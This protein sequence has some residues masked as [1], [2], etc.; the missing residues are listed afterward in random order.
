MAY[1]LAFA[2]WIA[3]A[4][5]PGGAWA[6]AA[7]IALAVSAAGVVRQTRAGLPL[8]AQVIAIGS[9]V[10]FAALAVL[11][12]A[13]PHT[14]LHAYTPALASGALALIGIGS[15]ALREPFTL[16]IAK[17]EMPREAWDHPEFL[18]VNVVITAVW[19]AS[20]AAGAV[21]L[22][23]LAHSPAAP[24]VTVQVAAFVVPMV[25]TGRYVAAARARAAAAA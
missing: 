1:L 13:D 18:R 22:A 9:A 16:G 20:F 15:L 21:A 7:L 8:D 6:W 11:A 19:T 2:P 23:F 25:F 5:V 12:F 17:Q 3:F 10:Y 24:R 14:A 4:V